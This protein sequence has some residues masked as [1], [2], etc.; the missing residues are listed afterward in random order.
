MD[1]TNLF[2]WDGDLNEIKARVKQSIESLAA[3]WTPEEQQECVQATAG[4]FEGGGA[5][6]SH[7]MGGQNPH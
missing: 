7:L 5:I 6:N 3:E 2:Q 1:G 4:A